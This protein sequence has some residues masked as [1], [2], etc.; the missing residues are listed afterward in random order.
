MVSL[1]NP[2]DPNKAMFDP[3]QFGLAH[4]SLADNFV[5]LQFRYTFKNPFSE[6]A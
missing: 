3:V 5:P 6:V 1:K 2:A 4:P